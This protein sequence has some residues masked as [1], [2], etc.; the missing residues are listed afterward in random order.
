MGL[1]FEF[2]LMDLSYTFTTML[3][4]SYIITRVKKT[5][6]LLH[7]TLANKNQTLNALY[8]SYLNVIVQ[9]SRK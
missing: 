7:G 1:V 6:I 5:S 2:I 8:R 3:T 9:T 4:T